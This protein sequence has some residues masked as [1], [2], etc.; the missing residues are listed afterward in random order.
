MPVGAYRPGGFVPGHVEAVRD[1]ADH[2]LRRVSPDDALGHHVVHR[3]DQLCFVR[4][5]PVPEGPLVK[6]ISRFLDFLPYG[7]ET[8]LEDVTRTGIFL[9]D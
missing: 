8:D 9:R 2:L 3:V 5:A 4:P 1:G 7:R 6:T